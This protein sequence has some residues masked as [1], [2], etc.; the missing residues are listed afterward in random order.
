[1]NESK[2]TLMKNHINTMQRE[3]EALAFYPSKTT[4][5]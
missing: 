4:N 2:L 3:V 1:M 5:Q